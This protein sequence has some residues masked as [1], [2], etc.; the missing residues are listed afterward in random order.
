MRDT[1]IGLLVTGTIILIITYLKKWLVKAATKRHLG[2]CPA[3]ARS[4]SP[5]RLA[6]RE[7]VVRCPGNRK[8]GYSFP[9]Y[10]ASTACIFPETD[11]SAEN[12][13]SERYH[14]P[15]AENIIKAHWG[16]N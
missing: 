7:F 4:P 15:H 9:G 11:N 1:F 10:H 12:H 6:S 2:C 14:H 8:S 3:R 13:K 16:N 5:D